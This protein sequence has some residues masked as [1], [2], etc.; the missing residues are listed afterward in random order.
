[1]MKEKKEMD[2]EKKVIACAAD[3][4]EVDAAMITLETNIREDLSNASLLMVA[5]ISGIEDEL[6]ATIE[7]RDAAKLF[8]IAD[9]VAKVKEISG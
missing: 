4:Y 1:M 5:F 6:D 3:V 9:F 7:L 8:T 2:I